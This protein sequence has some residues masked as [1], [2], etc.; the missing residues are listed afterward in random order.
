MSGHEG[1]TERPE[2]SEADVERLK[3]ER[4]ALQAE[5]EK[6][7]DR[8]E[9]RRR[10]RRI[11]TPVLVILTVVIFTVTVPA[12]WGNRTILNTDRYV[13][14]VAPLAEDPAVQAS[15]A[16][17]VTDRVFTALDVQGKLGGVLPENLTILAAPMTE[18]VRGF[19]EEQVLKLVETEAFARF[20]EEANRF[21]HTQVL[22][23][24]EGEGETVS[25]E[26][27][28]VLLNLMPLVNLAL[29]QI[30]GVASDLV[31]RD[32]TIPEV[33]P[34]MLP[35]QAVAAL[36]GALGVDL[37][38][39]YGAIAVYDS[40]ELGALQ[41]ALYVFQRLLLLLIVLIPVLVALTL[42]VSTRRRRTLIQL[43]AGGVAGLVLIRRGA[44]LLREN[45]FESVDTQEFPSVRVLTDQLTDS[46]FRY[47]AVLLAIVLV[48]LLVALVTG[49]YPWAVALRG[50]VRDA[51][52]SVGA[53]IGGAAAPETSRTRW[54]AEHRDGL[55]LGVAAVGVALV[56]FV[57]LSALWFLVVAVLVGL[58]EL[59]L[60]RMRGREAEPA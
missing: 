58:L 56:F 26:E 60:V 45:L 49:P 24:L 38:E 12:A 50:W 51:A 57:D 48:T 34:G 33:T 28:K 55:M 25:V 2:A 42:W 41:Q 36:E 23:I 4:D 14:T 16:R 22:A 54:I 39:D 53:A 32:V 17:R 18:A 9:R 44:L 35:D 52:R 59:G 29:V 43:A 13:S 21:A 15:L 10:V 37:P 20:W 46:L 3:A 1:E 11:L 27:G 30:Q 47:T 19:V 7:E 31:G 6:L 8:P 5:V 40:D